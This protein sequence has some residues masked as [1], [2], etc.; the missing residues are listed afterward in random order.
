VDGELREGFPAYLACQARALRQGKN[1]LDPDYLL[2]MTLADVEEFYRDERTGEVALQLIPER[3]ERFK[4]VGRVLKEKYGGSFLTLLERAQGYLFRDDGL[5]IIQQLI[6]NFPLTYGD[7]PFC[8]KAMVTIGNLYQDR[9]RLIPRDA[10][11][12]DLIELRDPEKLEIG[13]DY[14]R[15]YFFYRVGVLRISEPF[16][17]LLRQRKLIERDS[18]L[19]REYRAWTVLVG[20]ELAAELGV[21]PHDVAVETW[22]M[23]FVRCRSCFVGATDAEVPCSYRSVCLS[24]NADPALMETLWPLVLTTAY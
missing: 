11:E 2:S 13:A 16:K 8:K 20:R 21:T 7:W 10:P 22:G 4:E 15:P 14:Y 23:G 24:Y 12:R 1:I 6:T 9:D 3:L 19:E 5:G 18:P 17:N